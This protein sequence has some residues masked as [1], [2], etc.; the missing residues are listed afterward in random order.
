M[1]IQTKEYIKSALITFIV[2]FSLAVI[3]VLNEITLEG[4]KNGALGGL[5]FAGA[6]TGFKALFE[7]TV[8]VFGKLST[9]VPEKKVVTKKKK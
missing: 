2:G 6:R 8:S 7:W 4:V 3:P 9:P 5:I 1:T